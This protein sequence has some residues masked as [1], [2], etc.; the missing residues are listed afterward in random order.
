V[1]QS[2]HPRGL[3]RARLQA[4]QVGL[5]QADFLPALDGRVAAAG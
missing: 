1:P 5:A 2:D 3:V 4:A